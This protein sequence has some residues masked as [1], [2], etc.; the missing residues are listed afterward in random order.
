MP[1]DP[2]LRRLRAEL[3]QWVQR[4]W[5][6]PQHSES[7][8]EHA[9]RQARGAPRHI[10]AF[11]LLGALLLGAGVIMFFAANWDA[12]PK[13]AKL[14][15]LAAALAASYAGAG[16]CRARG[17]AAS[18]HGLLLLG[19][20]LFGASIFLIA[21]MYHI[22]AH[23]PD[24][25]LLWAA[26]ALAAA[27]L[28]QSQPALVAALVL[29]LLWSG[30]ETFAFERNP[31]WP[32]LPALV[33]AAALVY[34]Q[35]WLAAL[36]V[37]GWTLL[38]WCA[39][40][41]VADEFLARP[42]SAG[43]PLALL[44]LYAFAGIALYIVGRAMESSARLAEYAP[45]VV[46][47]GAIG[48]AAAWFA[49]SFPELH[50]LG[51]F[52]ALPSPAWLAATVALLILV[53]ALMVWRYHDTPLGSLPLYRKGAF[54]WLMLAAA[55]AVAGLL[56]HGEFPGWAA[57][58]YNV[59]AFAGALWMVLTGVDRGERRIVNLGIA[60]FGALILARYVDTFWSL[61]DRS[62]FFM[63]GGAL[64]LGAGVMLER[65]RRRLHARIVVAAVGA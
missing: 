37:A 58:G 20:V 29:A 13:L 15:L 45:P 30:I 28:G 46:M 51:T 43:E 62:Y 25:V 22:D 65:A 24:G 36:R 40:T 27:A 26:G 44:Q 17:L 21:Q 47:T 52:G 55:L 49:L 50:R 16:V 42:W 18:A 5:V 31:H 56:A 4:G 19:V 41:L 7:I 23:Y 63:V 11:G 57:L 53:A 34:A 6:T 1:T 54:V 38:I 39:F 48:A 33:A 59:L 60:C 8:L 12:L 35:R 10:A 14:A 2:F 64:L 61:L 3:P 9:A 32:F